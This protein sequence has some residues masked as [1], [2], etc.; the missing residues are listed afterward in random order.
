MSMATVL[1]YST[2]GA[3]D[4]RVLELSHEFFV[5]VRLVHV[6]QLKYVQTLHDLFTL[7]STPG[8]AESKLL[9]LQMDMQMV[10]RL[11]EYT[12]SLLGNQLPIRHEGFGPSVLDGLPDGIP[13]TANNLLALKIQPLV[14]AGALLVEKIL[15]LSQNTDRSQIHFDMMLG[16]AEFLP[17]NMPNQLLPWDVVDLFRHLA[18]AASALP[19]TDYRFCRLHLQRLLSRSHYP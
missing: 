3:T 9:G 11:L 13:A 4:G 10:T 15:E 17:K 18:R 8:T 6:Q 1:Y 2:Q 14:F 5:I 16:L 19:W 12:T 7:V